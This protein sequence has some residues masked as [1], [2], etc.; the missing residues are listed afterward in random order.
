MELTSIID[1]YRPRFDRQY[2]S[3]TS[4]Q[5]NRAINAVLDC[6]SER[7]G[8]MLLHCPPCDNQQSYFHA[9]GHCVGTHRCRVAHG[10]ARAAIE[11]VTVVKT[12]IRRVG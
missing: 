10:C 4:Q 5:L 3:R 1:R 7:Y 6:R 11:V 2:G 8:E 12:T 9:C